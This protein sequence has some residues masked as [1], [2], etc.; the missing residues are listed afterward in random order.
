M[1]LTLASALLRVMHFGQSHS[2][3]FGLN[4]SDKESCPDEA[5][6]ASPLVDTVAFMP[7]VKAGA[8]AASP[9][10]DSVTEPPG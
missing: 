3:G 9:L 1:H 7:N 8:A 5:E 2:P 4:I 10:D 6:G